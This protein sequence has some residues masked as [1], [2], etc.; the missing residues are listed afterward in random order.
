VTDEALRWPRVVYSI[1]QPTALVQENKVLVRQSTADFNA[2]R[3][4][5]Y[6]ARIAPDYLVHGL[7]RRM[8]R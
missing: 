1:C 2:R 3:W 4:E 6:Y 5:T 7:P 8:T